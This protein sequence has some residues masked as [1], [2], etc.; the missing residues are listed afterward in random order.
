LVVEAVVDLMDQM[1]MEQ[2]D[3]AVVEQHQELQ[4]HQDPLLLLTQ[5]HQEQQTLEVVVEQV[6]VDQLEHQEELEALVDQES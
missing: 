6:V 4:Q 3:Q 5:E 1:L 2:V